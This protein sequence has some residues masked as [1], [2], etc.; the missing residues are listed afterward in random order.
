MTSEYEAGR[1]GLEALIAWYSNNTGDRNEATTRLQLID[2]LFFECLG[3]SRDEM[4]PEESQGQEY[5]DYTFL[6]PRRILIVEAKKEGSYFELP[7]GKLRLEYSLPSL[8]RDNPNLKTAIEQAAGYCQSRGV[9]FG[10]VSNGHQIVA[11]IANRNDGLPP[12]EGKALVFSSLDFMLEHFVELWQALSKP[13]IEEKKLLYRLIGDLLPELP[14]KLSSTLSYYPGVKGRNPFQTDLQTLSELIIED[15]VRSNELRKRFLKECYSE[16]GALSQYALVSKTILQTR[17]SALFAP[18]VEGPT[19]IPVVQRDGISAELIAESLSRRPVILI[20]DV[21]VGKTTFI[22]HLIHVDAAPLFKDAI[23]IYIDLGSQATLTYDLRKF[24]L[25]E[26]SKQLREGYNIDIFERGFVRYLYKSDLDRFSRSIW[27]DLQDS[28]PD[29]YKQKEIELLADKVGN[30]EEHIKIT[31]QHV[32]KARRKQVVL[33]IDNTDQRDEATQQQAFLISQEIA[34]RWRPVTVFVALRP[35]TFY[36]SLR[37]GALSGY[38]PKAFTISPPRTE[39]VIHKRLRFALRIT[40]G[41]IPMQSVAGGIQVRL[42]NLEII[43]RVFLNSLEQSEEISECIENLAGGNIRLAL[44]FV[45]GFFGSG[46]V[47]TEKI[48]YIYEHPTWRGATYIIPLHEFLR[49]VI[50]GDAEHYDPERSPILNLFD[51]SH[52]DP[53]EH[54]LL[55]LTLGLLASAGGS[56]SEEGFVE[57]PA[58]YD[59][60]QGLGFTPEQIDTAIIRAHRK[61]LIDTT[62]RRIPQPGREMPQSLRVTTVGVYHITKLCRMFP[63]VDAMIV[64]TPILNTDDRAN[65][66]LVQSIH[67]RLERANKFRSYLNKQWELFKNTGASHLFDWTSMSRDLGANIEYIRTRV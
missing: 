1:N 31:L 41:E 66:P 26:I 27:A 22:R 42:K 61:K 36:R 29:L 67:E 56:G 19:T 43:I 33:F 45:R 8:F 52:L 20:G 48:V 6:A 55:P 54:F 57:T 14:A 13:G 37:I 58:V 50:F 46:H 3:W 11:F 15:L 40:S 30:E 18:E 17:Y 44:D 39:R 2:R 62:A 47:D 59:Q 10:A 23:T 9:P 64:D 32:A 7:A 49:A 28:N 16:S 60:I 5:A 12:L 38:H 65:M 53:K 51:L 4:I 21:G 34:E 63:Y 24:L 25:D 35:E